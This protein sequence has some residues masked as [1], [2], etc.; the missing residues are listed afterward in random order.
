MKIISK[1]V[2]IIKCFYQGGGRLSRQDR[3]YYIIDHIKTHKELKGL[4]NSV[5]GY[6]KD[7][8][9][10]HICTGKKPVEKTN[11][12]LKYHF[13]S[14]QPLNRT[15]FKGSA[16]FDPY[17]NFLNTLFLALIFVSLYMFFY[18]HKEK[19]NKWLKKVLHINKQVCNSKIGV[20]LI[21]DVRASVRISASEEKFQESK[22]Q[23]V[24]SGQTVICL[25]LSLIVVIP[26]YFAQQGIKNEIERINSGYMRTSVYIVKMIIPTFSFIIFPILIL[27]NNE[28]MQKSVVKDLKEFP[29][30]QRL[31]LFWN[32]LFPTKISSEA[33]LG[34]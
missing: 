18:A 4:G 21:E 23:I 15:E 26:V 31:I 17:F 8:L 14:G 24:G 2:G 1:F 12:T 33:S 30:I 7:E 3:R 22:S 27:S 6:H 34:K 32:F 11:L 29:F 19:Y 10:H 20:T 28:K 25:I 13:A 9:E 16:G 5:L